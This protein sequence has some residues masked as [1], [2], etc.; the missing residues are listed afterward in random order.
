VIIFWVVEIGL[1]KACQGIAAQ[2]EKF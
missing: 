2:L 1:A